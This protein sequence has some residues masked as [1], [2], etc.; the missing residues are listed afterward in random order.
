MVEGEKSMLR[1][2]AR[3]DGGAGGASAVRRWA[4]AVWRGRGRR[5][6]RCTAAAAAGKAAA[7]AE[8]C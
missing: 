8:G 4:G 1:L 7:A 3:G 6:R 5:G 2:V